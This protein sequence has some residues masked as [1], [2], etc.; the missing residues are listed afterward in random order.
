MWVLCN[1]T[2]LP[3]HYAHPYRNNSVTGQTLCRIQPEEAP[4]QQL[5]RKYQVDILVLAVLAVTP[6]PHSGPFGWVDA[7]TLLKVT[8]TKA[9]S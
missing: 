3:R 6:D 2:K 9:T 7:W 1:F 5:P 4:K 8:Y